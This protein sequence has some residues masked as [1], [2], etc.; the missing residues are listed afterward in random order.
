MKIQRFEL[1]PIAVNTYIVQDEESKKAIIVDPADSSEEL[2]EAALGLDVF[3][4]VNT[5]GH[6][7]HIAGNGFLK[8]KIKC[9]IVIHSA[10]APM[11]TDSLKNLSAP[12][13]LPQVSPPADIIIEEEGFQIKAGACVFSVLFFPGH[14]DGC[15]GLYNSA[16]GVLFS[17]DFIFSNTIGRTDFPGG[18]KL[19]MRQ[20]ILKVINLPDETKVYPGHDMP[21]VLKEFKR[22]YKDFMEDWL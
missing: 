19:K 8:E 15:I 21:F 7:D 4:I 22:F 5:H 20:S 18:D 17:G 11:L 13:F 10:D 16:E 6:F 1:G 3:Y 9:P 14:S 2:L 12:L